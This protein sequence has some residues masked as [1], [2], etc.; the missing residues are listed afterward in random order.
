MTNL[1]E[2][3]TNE[4]KRSIRLASFCLDALISCVLAILLISLG[5]AILGAL[6][7]FNET[8][9]AITEN[10]EAKVEIIEE[11]H[12]GVQKENGDF[13]TVS[14]LANEYLY[15]LTKTSLLRYGRQESDLSSIYLE[16]GEISLHSDRLGYYYSEFKP[17]HMDGYFDLGIFGKDQ[18]LSIL[19][20]ENESLYNDEVYPLLTEEAAAQIDEAIRNEDYALGGVKKTA[21]LNRYERLLQDA[22]EELESMYQP[23]LQAHATYQTAYQSFLIYQYSVILI[24]ALI[25]VIVCYMVLPLF[26]SGATISMKALHLQYTKKNGERYPNSRIF[27]SS[28]PMLLAVPC[29]GLLSTLLTSS[30]TLQ[31][32]TAANIFL[33]LGTVSFILCLV[34]YLFT[35]FGAKQTGREKCFGLYLSQITEGNNGK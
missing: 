34:N 26:L 4:V 15:S 5:N 21:I 29:I 22:C 8:V 10:A 31:G 23:Y 25:G 2:N 13:Y 33:L 27:L 30:F 19:I 1:S 35:F 28:L 11:S 32:G 18:Y 16:V 6:P 14:E 9:S 20:L 12:L 17:N 24:S 7:S 3:P